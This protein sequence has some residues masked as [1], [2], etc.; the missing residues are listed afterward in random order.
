VSA[1]G[2]LRSA[3]VRAAATGVDLVAP[4]PEGVVV[5]AYH[6]VGAPVPG[7]VNLSPG[8][9]DDQMAWLADGGGRGRPSSLDDAI[10]ALGP[11]ALG[12]DVDRSDDRGSGDGGAADGGSSPRVVVTFDDGTADFVE[13]AV[14]ALVRHGVPV[15]LYLATEHV[16]TGRS[17]WDDGTVLSWGALRDVL[18]TGL[19]TIGSHTHRHALLDRADATVDDELDRSIEL[20]GDRLG[21]AA[22]HFAYP[23]ALAPT[24]LADA[25][26]R[27]RFRSAALAGGRVNR[28]GARTDVHHLSRTP[29]VAADGEAAFRRKADGGLRLEGAL[30]ERWDRRRYA[31]STT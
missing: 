18:G 23:K 1:L 5:L 12:P 9:F 27:R 15:T 7:A 10:A 14:P 29:V 20:I 30:R 2:R 22:E 6:Q 31:G 17:F 25:A 26:V 28:P 19:V 24:P 11:S 13:H 16:E 21:V 4:P 8:A 3:T